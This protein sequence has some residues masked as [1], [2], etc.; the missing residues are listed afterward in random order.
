MK[1]NRLH[2][3]IVFFGLAL[4][5]LPFRRHLIRPVASAI[6]IAKGRSTVA[7]RVAQYGPAVRARLA[8][9]FKRIGCSYPP[10][11]M[12]LI[13]LKKEKRLEVWVAP[14]NSVLACLKTY[15]IIGT[16]GGLGPKLE[17]GDSQMPEGLYRIESLNPN[18]R[19]HL[20]LHVD[21]PNAYDR[22]KAA[23]DGRV[24]LGGDIMIHG[25][26]WS[27]GCLAMGDPAAEDLFIMAAET[28]L[29]NVSAIL[30]PVDFRIRELPDKKPK[31][32]AWTPELYDRIRQELMNLK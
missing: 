28:G 31:M 23:S 4:C 26:A 8:A 1:V 27:D 5:V 13:G 11:K 14:T 10:A 29:A 21:Y 7:E 32:P 6:S 2:I 3:L 18:S 22:A 16:S 17:E 15:P 12:V 19:Y 30:S 25:S 24:R 20:S 9:D